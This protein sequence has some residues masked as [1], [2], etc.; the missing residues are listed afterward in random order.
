MRSYLVAIPF[1][2]FLVVFQ[3]AV[4]SRIP[5]LEGKADLVMLAVLGWSLQEKAH[6]IWFWAAFGGLAVGLVTALPFGVM[7]VGYLIVL[8]LALFLKRRIWKVPF[9]SMIASVFTGTVIIDLISFTVVS[10]QG[11]PL[12]ILEVLNLIVLP[13]LLLN[14]LLAVPIY[15]VVRDIAGWLYPEELK[16]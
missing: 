10:L 4:I 12:S 6:G 9:L 8:G 13:S 1:L 11:T 16:V 15:I 3:S 5:L 7:L 14:L 2:S